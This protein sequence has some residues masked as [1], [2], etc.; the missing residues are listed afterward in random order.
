MAQS[1]TLI[2]PSK[3]KFPVIASK[4]GGRSCKWRMLLGLWLF[5]SLAA[6]PSARAHSPAPEHGCQAPQRPADD[7]NDALWQRFLDDVDGY[8]ACISDYAAASHAAAAAHSQAGNDATL[9][10]NAFVRDRL[11]VPEDYPWPPR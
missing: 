2:S 3:G 9:D 4:T 10:W 5:A 6:I 7:H 1:S 8:R 11:N